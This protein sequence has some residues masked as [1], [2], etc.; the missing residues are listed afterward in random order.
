MWLHKYYGNTR[1]LAQHWPQTKR[2]VELLMSNPRGVEAGLGDWMPVERP[3]PA[4]TGLAFVRETCLLAANISKIVGEPASAQAVYTD[5]AAAT[6]ANFTARFLNSSTGQYGAPGRELTQCG[7][8]L[9][10]FM[11]MVPPRHK[12]LAE[13][14]L[15]ESVAAAKGHM[16]VGMFGIKWFLLALADAGHTDLAYHAIATETY[17]S[18]GVTLEEVHT[19]P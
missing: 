18:Y 17:P 9:P 5:Y 3:T 11:G 6:L 15:V 13:A 2:F 19:P 16:L 10:L 8:A 4:M 14:K 7:Q 12:A 1:A